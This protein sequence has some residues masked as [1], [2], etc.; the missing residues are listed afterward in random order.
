LPAGNP[1]PDS[2]FQAGSAGGPFYNQGIE[3]RIGTDGRVDMKAII[4]LL[5]GILLGTVLHGRAAEVSIVPQPVSVTAG[6]GFFGLDGRTGLAMEPGNPHAVRAAAYFKRY[7]QEHTGISLETNPQIEGAGIL[8]TAQGA[9]S[10]L[11]AEGYLLEVVPEGITV[12]AGDYGG[13]FYGIQ[14]LL[15]LMPP[16][17]YGSSDR[18]MERIPV[19]CAGITDWPRFAWRG[20]LLDCSRQ[21]FPVEEVKRYI[22]GLAVHKINIFHW[23]L[24]DDDGWRIEIKAWPELTRRGAWRGKDCVLPA[25]HGSSPDEVYGGFY[26]QEDI[27]DVVDYAAERNIQ[28]L[29]EIDVPGHSQAVTAS[30]PETLCDSDE[31]SA[32]V[33]GVRKNVWCAGR[34]ANFEM[35]ND[36]VRETASLFPFGYIHIGGDEV[37]HRYWAS[38]TRCR[39]LMDGNDIESVE[40]IQ[41]YFIRRMEEILRR[42]GRKTIG[43][44]EILE[45]GNLGK[46]TA[47]MSWTSTEPGFRAARQGHP[48]VMSPGPYT[49]FDM[50]Q[51]PGER[52]HNW[53]G[54]IDAQ[55]TYSFD[56]LRGNELDES[57]QR[58]I[59]GVEACLWSEY[60]DKPERQI[61]IQTYPRLC[62]LAELCWTPQERRNWNDFA[63]RLGRA[64]L[65]RLEELDIRYRVPHPT[66][67]VRKG[68]VTILPPYAGADVRYTLDGTEPVRASAPWNGTPFPCE[69]PQRLRMKTFRASGRISSTI[70]GAEPY[71][72][73][74]WDGKTAGEDFTPW[75]TDITDSIDSN[76]GW[77]LELRHTGG[78][79]GID[80]RSLQLLENGEPVFDDTTALTLTKDKSRCRIYRM[81]LKSYADTNRYSV[82]IELRQAGGP[83]SR[84]ILILDQDPYLDPEVESV[85]SNMPAYG[86]HV[87]HNVADGNFNTFFWVERQPQAGDRL[88]VVFKHP[89]ACRQLEVITGKPN[90]AGDILVEGNLEISRDGTM[91]ETVSGFEHGSAR[92]TITEKIKAVRITCTAGQGGEWLVIQNLRLKP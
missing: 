61:D 14:T 11:P 56:P 39:S 74:R 17:V 5:C 89:V 77:M 75:E 8:F 63:D 62:A 30:Y 49:Y 46:D 51:Y 58:N 13:F 90:T 36:I 31:D 40:D 41:D 4:P 18:T 65:T 57:Q 37:N 67:T 91:F 44:N 33:Q 86:G 1:F 38:C 16:G 83:D 73:G 85:E 64:H 54:V 12:R 88:T 81:E 34:E 27:R 9:P 71:P 87:P 21:F 84:G 55:K 78:D 19:R 42:H 66:A 76:G 3:H 82:R 53:A 10:D 45:G 22:D 7:M 47:V 28:V 15:Q 59:L 6:E 43:W 68:R 92:T 35:L 79:H 60:L 50:A 70:R 2:V 25:S 48:V 32:S 24:T 20:M 52:G 72:C 69:N 29:P 26:T 23:H 80:V